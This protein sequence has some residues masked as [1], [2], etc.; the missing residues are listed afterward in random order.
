MDDIFGEVLLS[1]ER[2]FQGRQSFV[3]FQGVELLFLGSLSNST[4]IK[5][6]KYSLKIGLQ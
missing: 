4:F 5:K 2:Q 6:N 1:P 3:G